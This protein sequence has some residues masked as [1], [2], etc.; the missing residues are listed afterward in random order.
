MFPV[1]DLRA[2]GERVWVARGVLARAALRCAIGDWDSASRDLD[3]V[4]EIAE[5]GPMRLY[6]CDISLERARLALAQQEAFVPLIGLVEPS[7]SPPANGA[8]T[9]A[10]REEARK[11]L[12]IARKLIAECGYHRRD[13]ELAELD[14]VVSGQPPLRRSAP[15]RLRLIGQ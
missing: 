8:T 9:A 2:S 6:L 14:A 13:E 12:D 3:E 7:L 11:E 15:T 5:L 1:E 4:Q 10:L